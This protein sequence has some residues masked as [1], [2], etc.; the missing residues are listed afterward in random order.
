MDRN[1]KINTSKIFNVDP[2]IIKN[3]KN[4]EKYVNVSTTKIPTSL[5]ERIKALKQRTGAA[6]MH[7]VIRRAIDAYEQYLDQRDQKAKSK[8]DIFN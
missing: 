5:K 8:F 3:M 7:I 6:N 2:E 1:K 4:K